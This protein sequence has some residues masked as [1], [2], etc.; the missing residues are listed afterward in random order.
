MFAS[1]AA[2]NARTSPR[3]FSTLVDGETL[4]S[5]WRSR[6]TNAQDGGWDGGRNIICSASR[7]DPANGQIVTQ[8]Y[9]VPGEPGTRSK[10]MVEVLDPDLRRDTIRVTVS[11]QVQNDQ[12]AWS[13]APT[14]SGTAQ[15]LEDSIYT[16][17]RDIAPF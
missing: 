17:A 16:K 10:L 12:G 5:C 9:A 7:P 2:P 14:P 8:W 3:F 15:S 4:G 11:R 6:G 1:R 13:A